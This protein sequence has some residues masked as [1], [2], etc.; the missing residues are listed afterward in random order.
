MQPIDGTERVCGD[1]IDPK[2]LSTMLVEARQ[3]L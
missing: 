3:R 1:V 2:K